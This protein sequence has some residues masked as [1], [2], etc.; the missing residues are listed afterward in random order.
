[1]ECGEMVYVCANQLLLSQV[2]NVRMCQPIIFMSS[3]H[4]AH[5]SLDI[6]GHNPQHSTRPVECSWLAGFLCLST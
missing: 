5:G 6:Q 2:F 3:G 4:W 1:M